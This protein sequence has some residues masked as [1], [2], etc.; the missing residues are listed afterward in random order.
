MHLLGIKFVEVHVSFLIVMRPLPIPD[1]VTSLALTLF[2]LTSQGDVV[3]YRYDSSHEMP[4]KVYCSM[5][6]S[7]GENTCFLDILAALGS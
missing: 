5:P 1:T 6:K 4:R 3:N 2:R 7:A